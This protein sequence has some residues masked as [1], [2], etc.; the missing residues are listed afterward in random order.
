MKFT[1]R[2]WDN[3]ITYRLDFVGDKYDEETI[4][5]INYHCKA[6]VDILFNQHEEWF[7]LEMYDEETNSFSY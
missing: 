2:L 4:E 6:V 1:E 7:Q 5:A 3:I